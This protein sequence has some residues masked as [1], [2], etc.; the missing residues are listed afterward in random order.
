MTHVRVRHLEALGAVVQWG[1]VASIVWIVAE[2]VF[3]HG[4]PEVPQPPS[5]LP[6]KM[7]GRQDAGRAPLDAFDAIWSRNLRQTLIERKRKAAPPP[8]P[9]PP[10]P[11]IRLPKLLATFVES[12]RSWGLF[13]DQRG[14]QRVRSASSRIDGFDIVSV[15]TGTAR[16][17][18]GGKTHD[19]KVPE[20]KASRGKR[21][22]G[23]SRR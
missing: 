3:L 16:L 7:S 20:R 19:V 22:K 6:L 18:R 11:P 14:A 10:P 9:A 12:G 5:E 8:K 15:S 17:S 21:A 13:V 23:R 1:L 2:A 4:P